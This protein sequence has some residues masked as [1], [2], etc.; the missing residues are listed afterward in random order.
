MAS[1]GQTIHTPAELFGR[2]KAVIGMVHAGAMPGTPYAAAA[3][4]DIA[5][6]AAKEA[7]TLAE[8]GF[9]AIIVE[10][11]HDRP[12]V[13]GRQDAAVVA[14]MTLAVAAVR[15]AVAC[16]LGV[17]VLSGG[18]QE[19]LA[20]ANACGASFIRCENFAFAHVADEGL[21][22]EAAAGRLLRY[23]RSIGAEHVAICC[24]VKKKHASHSITADVS[25]GEAVHA[26]VFFG[27]DAVIVSGGFTGTAT[28]AADIAEARSATKLPV[29]VGSGVEPGSVA[30]LFEHADG[31]IVGSYI[32]TDGVWSN[33][34]DATRCR[35]IVAAANDCR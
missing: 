27:A 19:A 30:S 10:N 5:D 11:M 12:Y 29:L 34:I 26:F 32:K 6:A 24:D 15:A 23:R 1:H 35:E 13:H 3:P 31:L 21:L 33:G 14:G 2:E 16:P 8:A 25:L 20:I 18:E 28:S 7:A 17:Q 22:T 9:D 4:R